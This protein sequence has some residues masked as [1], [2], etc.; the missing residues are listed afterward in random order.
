MCFRFFL[1]IFFSLVY[2][3]FLVVILEDSKV[4]FWLF[5]VLSVSLRINILFFFCFDFGIFYRFQYVM[6]WFF[7]FCVMYISD[8]KRLWYYCFMK[9]D[10]GFLFV[11]YILDRKRLEIV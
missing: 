2:R 11:K 7:Q 10:L 5:L 8:E 1:D 6:E 9:N 3:S 4:F